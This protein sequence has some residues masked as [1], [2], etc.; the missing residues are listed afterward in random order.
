MF[1]LVKVEKN[2]KLKLNKKYLELN[3]HEEIL[4]GLAI[5]LC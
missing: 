4:N 3:M 2:L 5:I 1:C